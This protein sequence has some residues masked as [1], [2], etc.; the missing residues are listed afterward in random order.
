MD[1]RDRPVFRTICCIVRFGFFGLT[2]SPLRKFYDKVLARASLAIS[3]NRLF[4]LHPR[5]TY[6]SQ[7]KIM[8]TLLLMVANEHE[9]LIPLLEKRCFH[10]MTDYYTAE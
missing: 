4:C 3:R 2:F 7:Q 9:L 1:T 6:H 5:V 8:I 10:I